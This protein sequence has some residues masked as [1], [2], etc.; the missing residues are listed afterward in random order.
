MGSEMC[1]RD[2]Y[3]AVC[4]LTSAR[5]DHA[6]RILDFSLVLSN[7]IKHLNNDYDGNISLTVGIDTGP[8]LSAV[9]GAERFK[10]TVWGEAVDTAK[11]VQHIAPIGKIF[12]TQ[13]V[14]ER[15]N[16]THKFEAAREIIIDA[17]TVNTYE[18]ITETFSE[19][20]MPESAGA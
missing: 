8:I 11:A 1:I 15:L 12:V 14:H 13:D 19:Q 18:L 5:L 4:G 9:I 10:F 2:S 3:T 17:S 16:T 20:S 6:K 7:Q